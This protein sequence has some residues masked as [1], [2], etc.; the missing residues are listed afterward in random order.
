MSHSAQ[1]T[2]KR[3][4]EQQ[5]RIDKILTVHHNMPLI[6][7]GNLLGSLPLTIILWNESHSN[8]ALGWVTVIY[9]L[10]LIRWLHYRRLDQHHAS[11][12][13]ILDQDKAYVLFAFIS[14]SVWG[15]SG[16]L[17][18]D[19][20]AK[21][22]FIFLFLSL[23]AMTSGSM[24]SLSARP[25]NYL[26]FAI[27]SIL[28]ITINLFLQEEN[29]FAWMWLG[30]LIYLS[31]T[32]MLGFNLHQSLDQAIRL[33]HEN[34]DLIDN[35]KCQT[36]AALSASRD[37]SR[38]L[39]AASHDLRQPLH[40]VNLFVEGLEKKLTTKAQTHDLEHIRLGL[41]SLD[42]LFNALLDMSHMD[43]GSITV[44][45][46][47]FLIDPLLQKLATQFATEAKTKGLKLIIQG[48][49]HVIHSDPVLLERIIRN[50]LGNA[51]RYTKQGQVSI[52]C[53]KETE[54]H[55]Y[56]HI[57]DTGC[58]IP[59]EYHKDVFSE[60]FQLDNPERNRDKGLGLG[61]AIVQRLLH[62]LN[63]P[64]TLYSDL[65]KGTKFM[66]QIPIGEADTASRTI[67]KTK[68]VTNRVKHL[69]VMVIDNEIEIINA[70][71]TLLEGWQCQCVAA[72]SAH[73]ALQLV[74]QGLQPDLI[75]SDYRLPGNINGC[76]LIQSLQNSLG[77]VPAL[78]ISGDTSADILQQVKESG[79]I[80]LNKPVKP[81]Q[82]RLTI[83]RLIKGLNIKKEG[84]NEVPPA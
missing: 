32:V 41:H 6:L 52:H 75:I 77:S 38:F 18:L 67:I 3:S 16:L 31:L 27:P 53:Q 84:H 65:G 4:D 74:E 44:N 39:A 66:I 83:N 43:A 33:R 15:S 35:L 56:L 22:Q 73:K 82:L 23:F 26:A 2:K 8:L 63:H 12:K 45:K 50:L 9:F 42:E 29:F 10:T 55:L 5:I 34:R 40:A 30:A 72:D 64:I 71:K 62:L 46:I 7:I 20:E 13:H 78:L 24:T 54:S 48:C 59:K 61:L 70:M 69:L 76:K 37:K 51:I 57:T 68:P 25:L 81:A 11:P 79:L 14:G 28:P 60:F 80:L 36:D 17:F 49:E 47:D 1:H 21:E 58:G 19:S